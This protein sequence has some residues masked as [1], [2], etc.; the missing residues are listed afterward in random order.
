MRIAGWRNWWEVSGGL[1]R[2]VFAKRTI[3]QIRREGA[4]DR[5]Q[6]TFARPKDRLP[7]GQRTE[8]LKQP[9][10]LAFV[11]LVVFAFLLRWFN[12]A[13]RIFGEI[14]ADHTPSRPAALTIGALDANPRPAA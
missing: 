6:A 9:P 5:R 10:L 2:P 7:Q 8:R 4:G 12:N 14:M 1:R 11:D 13:R 3:Q